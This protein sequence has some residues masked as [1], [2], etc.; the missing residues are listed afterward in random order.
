MQINRKEVRTMRRQIMHWH[1]LGEVD[2]FFGEDSWLNG[3]FSPAMDVYQDGDTVIAKISLPDI[4]PKDVEVSVENDVLTV[5]G[6]KKEKKEIKH[7]DYYRKEIREGSFS[8]SVVLPMKVKS[9]ETKA[10]Y[11][12]GVLEITMPKADEVR[13]K[14]IA[15]ASKED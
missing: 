3:N 2:Q 1:P 11:T 15:I 5:S 10:S 14:R 6:Q 8:R 13:P 7:E 9:E 12:K 4:D